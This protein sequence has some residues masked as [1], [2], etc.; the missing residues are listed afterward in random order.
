MKSK[1]AVDKRRYDDE[2]LH[3]LGSPLDDQIPV[4][5]KY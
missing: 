3:S 2:L 5:P 4:M 1:E